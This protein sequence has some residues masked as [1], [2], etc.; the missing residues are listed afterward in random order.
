MFPTQNIKI[1]T[2]LELENHQKY[3]F[4]PLKENFDNKNEKLNCQNDRKWQF[5]TIK[6]IKNKDL[7]IF[8]DLE[9]SQ[10]LEFCSG[11]I[12]KSRILAILK[13]SF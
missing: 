13:W 4:D 11:N 7:I 5:E 10:E 2:S 8:Q 1:L 9:N 6:I 3:G 12:A